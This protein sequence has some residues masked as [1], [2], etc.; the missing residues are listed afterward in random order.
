M[1]AVIL[2]LSLTASSQ[3]DT[4]RVQ[5]VCMPI[6]TAQK[7]AADLIRL[8]SVTAEI[9]NTQAILQ[10]TEQKVSIQDSLIAVYKERVLTYQKEIAVQS[11]R[12]N[13]CS[14]RI[15]VVEKEVVKLASKNKVLKNWLT[16][17]GGGL[18]VSVGLLITTVILK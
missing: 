16:G 10:K 12:F 17:V 18:I 15:T 6:G 4:N 13:T 1:L 8:D 7:I 2:L 5:Q 11:I 3:V 9:E 14:Q